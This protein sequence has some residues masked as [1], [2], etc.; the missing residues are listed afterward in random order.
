MA[1]QVEMTA[2]TILLKGDLLF[3]TIISVREALEKAFE[4]AGQAVVVDFAGVQRVDSS[5]V[6]LWLCLERKSRALQRPLKA[7]NI[8]AE[9]SAIVRLVGLESTSLTP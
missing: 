1:A 5:A 3:S 2:D 4:Q 7:L 8:P 6:S 9:L